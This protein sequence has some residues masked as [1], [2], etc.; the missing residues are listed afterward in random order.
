MKRQS[1][2]IILA[3]LLCCF[4]AAVSYGVISNCVAA[5]KS[6]E[7]EEIFA[8]TSDGSAYSESEEFYSEPVADSSPEQKEQLNDQGSAEKAAEQDKAAQEKEEKDGTDAPKGLDENELLDEVVPEHEHK[9]FLM[10]EKKATCQE[11]GYSGDKYC[12]GCKEII[13]KGH[14]IPL[15]GHTFGE[16]TTVADPTY[17]A[18]GKQVRSC[19]L[20][21]AE[22][23]A[24]IPKLE[25]PPILAISYKDSVSMANHLAYPA[26][27]TRG[28][29]DGDLVNAENV[30]L[31]IMAA[32]NTAQDA[33][34]IPLPD[35]DS[36]DRF[37]IEWREKYGYECGIYEYG[38]NFGED[39]SMSFVARFSLSMNNANRANYDA[40]TGATLAYNN[41][42]AAAVQASGVYAGQSL[43]DALL[44]M[45]N[46]MCAVMSYDYSLTVSDKKLMMQTHTGTCN[47]YTDVFNDMCAYAGITARRAECTAKANGEYHVINRIY[48]SNGEQLYIDVTWNDAN[49]TLNYFLKTREEISVTHQLHD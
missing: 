35:F 14:E 36:C 49:S 23:S 3:I 31:G 21:G 37:Q 5:S 39:G 6:P 30:V 29:L 13:E 46:W 15:A 19:T 11:K 10:N 24:E 38:M 45:N 7:D 9:P 12:F 47:A 25:R 40:S 8:D 42:I 18:P 48:F 34:E 28:A 41:Q 1:L 43:Y 17:D 26:G 27:P 33:Y 22:E 16:W 32:N 2:I 4:F 20:C 44:A